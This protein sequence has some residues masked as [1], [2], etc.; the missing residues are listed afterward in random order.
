VLSWPIR[1]P[2][3]ALRFNTSSLC[4]LTVHLAHQVTDQSHQGCVP[5]F[6][7]QNNAASAE[8]ED[9]GDGDVDDEGAVDEGVGEAEGST[10]ENALMSEASTSARFNSP[11]GL[12]A[13]STK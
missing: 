1:F 4:S 7:G 12:P 2:F 3:V 9:D 13:L 5:S 11:V 6:C 10:T 8:D